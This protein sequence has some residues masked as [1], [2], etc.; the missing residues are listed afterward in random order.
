MHFLPHLLAGALCS[1]SVLAQSPVNALFQVTTEYKE[2]SAR[3]VEVRSDCERT[4]SNPLNCNTVFA[5]DQLDVA[6]QTFVPKVPCATI[7]AVFAYVVGNATR[8]N[9]KLRQIACEPAVNTQ[10]AAKNNA[11]AFRRALTD[12]I[13]KIDLLGSLFAKN[14]ACNNKQSPAALKKFADMVTTLDAD[15]KKTAQAFTL[16][17]GSLGCVA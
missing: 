17:G 7:S 13:V 16:F 5:N 4:L 1:V 14:N 10:V 9:T 2:A 3:L 15:D 11:E 8:V 6:A 12:Q